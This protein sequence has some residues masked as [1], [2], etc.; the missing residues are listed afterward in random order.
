MPS[1]FPGMDP[2][3]EEPTL[4]LG[5]HAGLIAALESAL[6]AVLPEGYAADIGERVYLMDSRRDAYP[7]VAVAQFAGRRPAPGAAAPSPSGAVTVLDPAA[8]P[9]VIRVAPR[10][11]R[12][13]FLQIR[14]VREGQRVVTV[15]EIL[16]PSNKTVGTQSR[17]LYLEKQ[18]EPLRS[19]THLLEIDLLRAGA[20]TVAAPLDYLVDR[21]TWDYLVCLH[22]GSTDELYELWP[23]TLRQPLPLVKVPLGGDDPDVSLGLGQVLA[24]RYDEGRYALKIDYRADPVP[25]LGPGDQAWAAALLRERGLR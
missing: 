20:H 13:P 3:L 1:P 6:N 11:V 21:G 5:V 22:R 16:S 19:E 12:E 9:W 25:P 10:E 17:K 15:I 8:A 18:A 2:Y 24:R 7:D 4:W 14:A 23:I